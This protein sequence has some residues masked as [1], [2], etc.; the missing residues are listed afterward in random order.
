MKETAS[1]R[2][3]TVLTLLLNAQGI[4]PRIPLPDSLLVWRIGR[5]TYNRRRK[6]GI[7]E[8]PLQNGRFLYYPAEYVRQVLENPP[9]IPATKKDESP[10]TVE[11]AATETVMKKTRRGR[12]RKQASEPSPVDEPKG[13]QGG[14]VRHRPSGAPRPV[15]NK[16]KTSRQKGVTL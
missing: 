11:P 13:N 1:S 6:A 4:N 3:A 7:Y 14:M 10:A 2:L 12:S 15:G 8:P 16:N 5:S 9:A